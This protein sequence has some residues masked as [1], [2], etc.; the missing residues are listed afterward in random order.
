[1]LKLPDDEFVTLELVH[2]P[3]HAAAAADSRLSHLVIKVEAMTETVSR[4]R[5][6]GIQI[7]EPTSPEGSSDFLTAMLFDPDGTQIELVQWPPGHA[8]GMSAADFSEQPT[9]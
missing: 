6:A 7:G 3:R 4:L 8:D 9:T 2:D 5:A 1:M